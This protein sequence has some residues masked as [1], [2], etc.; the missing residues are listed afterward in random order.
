MLIWIQDKT[1]NNSRAAEWTERLMNASCWKLTGRILCRSICHSHSMTRPTKNQHLGLRNLNNLSAIL[2]SIEF[3]ILRFRDFHGNCKLNSATRGLCRLEQFDS[4][5][6]LG[7]GNC[8]I[9]I[10]VEDTHN[11]DE[12]F[13]SGNLVERFNWMQVACV[14]PRREIDKSC[15]HITCDTSIA[16]LESL[17]PMSITWTDSPI[18]T[19]SSR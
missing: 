11:S 19:R 7:L 3:L 12:W 14:V 15:P 16:E 2:Q 1:M 9:L 13:A 4:M 6:M 17:P 8:A 5:Q 18:R 10:W